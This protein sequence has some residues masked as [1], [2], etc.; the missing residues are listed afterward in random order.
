MSFFL[1][2]VTK[3]TPLLHASE[4]SPQTGSLKKSIFQLI[5]L[6]TFSAIILSSVYQLAPDFSPEESIHVKLPKNFDD[7]RNLGKVLEN[8]K[9]THYKSVLL[10]Y[11]TS[12]LF[13]VS[14][15]I[16]GSTFLSVLAGFLY[17]SW[18]A[19]FFVC[20]SSAIGAA[21]CYTLADATGKP[22]VEKYLSEKV[23]KWR[24]TVDKNRSDLMSY[25]LF[26]RITPFLPNWF[27]NI[28]SPCLNIPINIFFWATFFGVAPLSFIAVSAGKEIHKLVKFGDAL[29]FDA[30][31]LCAAA[32]VVS[33]LP[34]LAKK[35]FAEKFG[36]VEKDDKKDE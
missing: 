18:L 14:F 19:M 7:A 4:N 21:F 31:F 22:F 11:F 16:P 35:L 30:V 1:H 12:Y 23:E 3:K 2:F 5:S 36:M 29:S 27:I 33:I 20:L 6:F 15:S 8:Y 34:I 32:A 28:T 24:I 9:D 13:L 26:L 25:I 17:P 10:C